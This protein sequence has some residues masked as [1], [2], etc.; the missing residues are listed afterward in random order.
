MALPNPVDPLPLSSPAPAMDLVSGAAPARVQ[1]A[2][3]AVSLAA[4]LFGLFLTWVHPRP[5]PDYY[6]AL[7]GGRDVA[8]GK[9]GQPDDWSFLTGDRV[10][11]HQNWGSD[12]TLYATQQLAGDT[13]ILALKAVLLLL[14]GWLVVLCGRARGA[15]VAA[16]LLALG[17]VGIAWP[18]GAVIRANLFSL[19]WV[20][21]LLWT[22][23]A[24]R[25]RPRLLWLT[26]LMIGVWANMHGAF[27]FGIGML[28]LWTGCRWLGALRTRG[29][30][31]ATRVA[32][33]PLGA[34][35]AA[36]IVAAFG[37]PFGPDNL[38]LSFSLRPGSLWHTVTEWMPLFG[39][40]IP[41][42]SPV[43]FLAALGV[44][45]LGV[46]F[47][48]LRGTDRG[49][50]AQPGVLLFEVLLVITAVTMAFKA[51]RFVLFSLVAIAP[52]LAQQLDTLLRPRRRI[53]PVALA[54]LAVLTLGASRESML[55][56]YY[57]TPREPLHFQHGFLGRMV[58]EGPEMPREAATFL[59]TNR[60]T[61]PAF[62]HYAWEGYLHWAAP[63]L[64]LHLGGRAHQIYTEDEF[65]ARQDVVR[66]G[67]SGA[68]G[69]SV[70]ERL[71]SIGAG[72]VVVPY[73]PQY[74][75]MIAVLLGDPSRR[76][77]CLYGDW[78]SMVLI[79]ITTD[80]GRALSRDMTRGTLI[81]PDPAIAALSRG[82]WLAS[83]AVG[84]SS[85]EAYA[86]LLAALMVKPV[87]Y[88]YSILA[89]TGRSAGVPPT[90]LK[91][92]L[93][94]ERERL[95]GWVRSGQAGNSARMSLAEVDRLLKALG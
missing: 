6:M 93:T 30:I 63:D 53:L 90:E 74:T 32:R 41:A 5:M 44:L 34:T 14:M 70:N 52:L 37:T 68:S 49:A 92:I 59:A 88:A 55:W 85:R 58:V 57:R 33:V 89:S 3:V 83:P 78:K 65:A 77:A 50:S 81:F 48:L 95:V 42:E 20:P 25:S 27:V 87:P 86:S 54:A 11:I 16:G 18:A 62:N 23:Y 76:W 47:R 15:S 82:L 28:G 84:G 26:P 39:G 75:G 43:V 46:L 21:L 60:L 64:P 22:L 72:L 73:S 2:A 69:P 71:A 45:G 31:G 13:G 79:D 56:D 17:L 66:A 10:W 91:R 8:Q 61:L 36:V 9:L 19:V 7:A 35:L 94:T 29:P 38:T 67:M 12:L 51:R 80:D 4:A 1:R 24:S 40:S